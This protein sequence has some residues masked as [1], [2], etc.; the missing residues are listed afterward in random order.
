MIQLVYF[1][2]DGNAKVEN[3][4]TDEKELVR[5]FAYDYSVR[6]YKDGCWT[7]QWKCGD[8]V[9]DA[10]ITRYCLREV[11]TGGTRNLNI[12]D[13]RRAI[14]KVAE[15]G[16]G[17]YHTEYMRQLQERKWCWYGRCAHK[18]HK[19]YRRGI[20]HGYKKFVS[21]S[22]KASGFVH[23]YDVET[24]EE[25]TVNVGRELRYNTMLAHGFNGR[26]SNNWKDRKCR[27]SWQIRK[28]VCAGKHAV[29][30]FREYC[31]QELAKPYVD[32]FVRFEPE[33]ESVPDEEYDKYSNGKVSDT[34][35][36]YWLE[37][38]GGDVA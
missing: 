4:F 19:G 14:E 5:W 22:C 30:G 34:E 26:V 18:H 9:C 25:Y 36:N 8:H 33:V 10:S 20:R 35:V 11:V 38:M 21:G 37:R 16:L 6:P 27:S 1:L 7:Y 31:L 2:D 28:R 15:A 13:Y 17:I 23:C 12:R 32:G 24:D 29:D 3:V